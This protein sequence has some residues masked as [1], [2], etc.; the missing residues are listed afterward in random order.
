MNVIDKLSAGKTKTWYKA[1]TLAKVDPGPGDLK[2]EFSKTDN[3]FRLYK[4]S[5]GS[6]WEKKM[7]LPFKVTQNMDVIGSS[8]FILMIGNN[9]ASYQFKQ[10]VGKEYLQ[11]KLKEWE[12]VIVF[13]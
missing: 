6:Q 1:D 2:C 10:E 13:V 3:K 8:K 9:E 7:E 4:F 11:L 5:E 12:Y